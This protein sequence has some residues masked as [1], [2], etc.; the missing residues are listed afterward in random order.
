MSDVLTCYEDEATKYGLD[1]AVFI[2]RLR[3]WLRYHRDNGETVEGRT[4]CYN[5]RKALLAAFPFWTENQIRRI[6]EQLRSGEHP[7]IVTEQRPGYDRTTWYA[8]TDE[9]MIGKTTKASVENH[10]SNGE[11]PPIPSVENHQSFSGESPGSLPKRKSNALPEGFDEWWSIYPRKVAKV[12]AVKAYRKALL[13]T[14]P[15]R[16]LDGARTMAKDVAEGRQ[17]RQWVPYPASWLN[18]GR[19]D[20]EPTIQL[21]T[22]T[23]GP[24]KETHFTLLCRKCGWTS[25]PGVL[26]LNV[27]WCGVCPVPEDG[28]RNV[29]RVPVEV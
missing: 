16:L 9:S 29:D 10:Q 2:Q 25:P 8:F 1:C 23:A 28:R 4:W 20:D 13:E 14:T 19:W 17:E 6:V 22:V 12:G 7:V 21:A 11:K 15:G 5:S 18:G 3:G 27:D 24:Q 26:D